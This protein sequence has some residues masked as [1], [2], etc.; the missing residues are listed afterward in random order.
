[1]GKLVGDHLQCH[2]HGLRYDCT[3]QCVKVPGQS[4][5]P[6]SAR[7]R[8]YPVVERYRWLWVFM[9]DPVQADPDMITD[10]VSSAIL[11]VRM[12][13]RQPRNRRNISQCPFG[14]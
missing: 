11:R 5:I 7:V 3:G 14:K 4:T 9:G 2:Y 8:S 1:M 10:F 13:H 12:R 6:P